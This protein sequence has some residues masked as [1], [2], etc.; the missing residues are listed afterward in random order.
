VLEIALEVGVQLLANHRQIKTAAVEG[1]D[2]AHAFQRLVQRYIAHAATHKLD[3]ANVGAVDANHADRAAECG[4]NI[5][6][7]AHSYYLSSRKAQDRR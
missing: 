4:L 2:C 5:Q 6:V 3:R 1:D 7:G